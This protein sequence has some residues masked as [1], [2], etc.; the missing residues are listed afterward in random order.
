MK[1]FN[2]MMVLL[3][4]TSACK[5]HQTDA[6]PASN[7]TQNNAQIVRLATAAGMSFGLTQLQPVTAYTIAQQMNDI[8][9]HTV[10]PYLAGQNGNVDSSTINQIMK[11][12]LFTVI[13]ATAQS[14]ISLLSPILDEYIPA[15]QANVY[16]T[17]TQLAYLTAFTNG[18]ED[19]S[20]AYLAGHPLS[21]KHLKRYKAP[22]NWLNLRK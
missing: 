8:L 19:G 9:I 16:L 7:A 2:L 20:S 6:T 3:L 5:I 22:G 10:Q 11:D 17:P 15:P 12:Q 18:L 13:P 1:S 14:L 21:T 4:C